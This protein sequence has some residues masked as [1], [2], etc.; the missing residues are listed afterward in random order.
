MRILYPAL[1]TIFSSAMASL[2]IL[3]AQTTNPDANWVDM[4]SLVPDLVLDIRYATT[5]NFMEEKI[6]DCGECY[7]RKEVADAIARVHRRIKAQGYG[8]LKMYDCYRPHS[9][10]WKLW[11]K[12][13]NTQYVADPRKGSMH[14]RGSAVDLTV[15][16]KNGKELDMGTGFDVFD[17]KAYIDYTG[18]PANINNNRKLLQTAM[19][20]KAFERQGRSG[21]IFRIP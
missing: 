10:Q 15:V 21:G 3:S 14:N 20:A 16:D 1:A 17:K 2:S 4:R 19:I 6:Y 5:N 7:L 12:V 13:P 11:K 18:H 9:A 8:G